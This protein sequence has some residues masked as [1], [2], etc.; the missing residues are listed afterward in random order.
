MRRTSEHSLHQHQHSSSSLGMSPLGIGHRTS[1]MVEPIHDARN[2]RPRSAFVPDD[3]QI[4]KP[5]FHQPRKRS[6]SEFV[7]RK[8][9]SSIVLDPSQV[10]SIPHGRVSPSSRQD[11][12]YWAKDAITALSDD[13]RHISLMNDINSSTRSKGSNISSNVNVPKIPPIN[14]GVAKVI[15][16]HRREGS[17]S[18]HNSRPSTPH[19]SRPSTPHNSRPNTP[20][21]HIYV[22]VSPMNGN[23]NL[24]HTN[25]NNIHK[26]PS[27]EQ[28][29]PSNR[30]SVLYQHQQ[31]HRI[32]S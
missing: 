8:R 29:M 21:S 6:N 12:G 32:R 13:F 24:L 11:S 31:K 25:N 26:R 17:G 10:P 30:N 16:R 22:P 18:S 27:F 28:L 23:R 5:D 14:N 4:P 9:T 2:R 15:N 19:N 7:P 1:L 3:R 20:Q